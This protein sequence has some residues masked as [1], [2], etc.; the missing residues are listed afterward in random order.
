MTNIFVG[1]LPYDISESQLQR[2]FER[3]GRVSS[4]RLSTDRDTQRS[5]GFAFV[6]MPSLDDAEEAITRLSGVVID[7]RKLTINEAQPDKPNGPRA[8]DRNASRHQALKMFD[9][10]LCDELV[11]QPV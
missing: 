1:N 11:T 8:A 7:G 9:D 6:R 2:T 5:R 4:V 10:L 3:F